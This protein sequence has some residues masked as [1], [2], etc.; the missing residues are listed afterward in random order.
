VFSIDLT[1]L[2]IYRNYRWLYL[3]QMISFMGSMITYVAIP[4]QMYQLTQS[5]FYVGLLGVVQ[6]V[7][8]VL[9]G[10]WGGALADSLNRKKL[11]IMMAAASATGNLL[12][13][14]FTLSGSTNHY[15]LF[16]L[17]GLMAIGKGLERPAM[18]A[19]TQQL[20]ELKD[21]PKVSTLQS[22][23]NTSG[24]IL[25]PAL[26]GILISNVGIAA[27]YFADFL[28]YLLSIICLWQLKDIPE[29]KFRKKV[30]FA[31][32]AEGFR[33][34]WSRPDLL[35][36]YLVDMVAMTFAYPNPLFPAIAMSLGDASKLGWLYSAP[37]VG[38]MLATLT[39][40]WTH[41]AIYHGRIIA[42]TALL[43]CVGIFAF[44]LSTNFYLALIFLGLAGGVDMISGIFRATI[45]N[46][47]IPQEYRGRLA[48]VEM[49]SYS[50]G[51]L[52]GNTFMGALADEVGMVSALSW[53]AVA[54]SVSVIILSLALKAF[55]NYRAQR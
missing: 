7:P 27:T 19:L 39:S 25:G 24:L 35:G 15:W 51:P 45:W 6:L 52:L 2:K 53:G 12:L 40:G 28:T 16:L 55:W 14:L 50:S 33:Y 49:I 48:S 37:A 23:K 26:G 31:A 17:S 22:F 32:I 36:T 47:T 30:S 10:I 3:G 1:P 29:L 41:R 54:G 5:T 21:L 43:W 4:F 44:G 11:A 9:S 20:V 42:I 38:A 18:E 34:A 46:E 8:L 13:M